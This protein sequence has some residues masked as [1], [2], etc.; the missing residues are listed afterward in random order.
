MTTL[1]ISDLHLSES[2]PEITDLFIRFMKTEAVKAEKLYILGDFFEAWIGDDDQSPF[3]QKIKESLLTATQQGL[4]I[5]FMYGNRDF[6][7]GERFMQDTGCTLIPEDES[8][9]TLDAQRVLLMHGD[10]LCSEDI[11]YQ[12]LRRVLRHPL[13]IR[14]FKKLPLSFRQKI[15][16]ELRK[17]SQKATRKKEYLMMDVTPETVQR[18]LEKHQVQQLIHGHTHQPKVHTLLANGKPASRTVLGAWGKTGW[19]LRAEENSQE[20]IEIHP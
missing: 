20:L 9:I 16:S 6:L 7:L 15:A 18:A 8:L 17:K 4:K 11:N 10:T 1:F 19:V 14:L 2:H 5:S 12:R 13:T 3:H